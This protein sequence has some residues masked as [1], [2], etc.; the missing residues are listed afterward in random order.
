M[1]NLTPYIFS[2]DAKKQAE[3]YS[4]VLG[5]SIVSMQTYGEMPD[6]AEEMK[7]K[8]LHLV[9]QLGEHQLYM[10]DYSPLQPGN[11]LDLTVEFASE[12]EARAAFNGLGEGGKVIF[13]LEKM[14]W[15]S[16]LGRVEDSYGIR[17]QIAV[18]G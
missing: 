13:P 11:Q 7:D 2:Q 18:N 12:E 14:A 17:W 4:K 3:F 9:L 1:I 8:V 15:G 6:S 5:G 10:A 16:F